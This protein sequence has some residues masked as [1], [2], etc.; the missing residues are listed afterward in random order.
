VGTL[1]VLANR[2]GYKFEHQQLQAMRDAATEITL[3]IGKS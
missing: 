2:H 1:E 3:L